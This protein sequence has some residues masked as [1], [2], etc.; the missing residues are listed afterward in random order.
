M[1]NLNNLRIVVVGA[2]NSTKQII[3]G[4]EN[5]RTKILIRILIMK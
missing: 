5:L 4:L 3:K 1:N 2:V